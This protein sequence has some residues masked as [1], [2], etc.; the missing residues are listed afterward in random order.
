M[1]KIKNSLSAKVFF[2]VMSMLAAC[3]LLL[4]GIVMWIIPRQY[5]TLSNRRIHESIDRLAS[6]LAHMDSQTAKNS[7]RDFCMQNHL[8]AVLITGEDSE[9]FGDINRISGAENSFTVSI[10]LQFANHEASSFLNILCIASTAEELNHT[11]LQLLPFVFAA[12]LLVSAVSAWLCSRVMVR[13]VLKLCSVAKRMA[14]LDMTW[15]CDV[16]R[17]DELG[18]L[19]ASL[20]T[21]SQRLTQ[22]M[23]ELESANGQLRLEIAAVNAAEKQRRDFF[24]AASHEL[25]TPVTI[26]KGQIESMLLEIGKYKDVKRILPETLREVE[27]MEQLVREILSISR[28]EING[29]AG[30]EEQV[31]VHECLR[32][33]LESLLPLAQEKNIEIRQDIAEAWIS[34]STALFR[35]A[36]HNI[37][38]NAVRHSPANSTVSIRLSEEALTVQNTGVTLPEEEIPRL[39]LPF[40][41][42]EKSRSK[43]T[44][45]SGLGLYLVKTILELHRLPFAITSCDDSVTF[46][47]K[48]L[49]CGQPGHPENGSEREG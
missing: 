28:L 34:G 17:S 5:T 21:L 25:K 8:A 7:I 20:N 30:Q 41:R 29:L 45:G 22:A 6:E 11:F 26:L 31:A 44:G 16:S 23:E 19:A 15:Q 39:F 3:S 2:W 49:P 12:I 24:A 38:S 35:K 1:R 32:A 4:Y 13:P 36:V 33:A 9:S 37:L 40:Y 43:R 10:A 46:T 42:I 48:L 14:Q 18:I 27:N 47:V